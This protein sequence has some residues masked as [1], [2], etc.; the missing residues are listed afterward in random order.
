[1]PCTLTCIPLYSY[2]YSPVFSCIPRQQ[3]REYKNTREFKTSEDT[4][5]YNRI[6]R[7]AGEDTRAREYKNASEDIRESYKNARMSGDESGLQKHRPD[8]VHPLKC[9]PPTPLSLLFPS[10]VAAA[11]A[12]AVAAAAAPGEGHVDGHGQGDGGDGVEGALKQL[13]LG[14]LRV[15][16]VRRDLAVG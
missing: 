15:Q 12:A 16:R 11:A 10:A 2:S 5:E 7:N 13:E 9:S 14:F 3:T 6:Q 4:R 1:M 8:G